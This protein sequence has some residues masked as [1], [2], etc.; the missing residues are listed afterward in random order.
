MLY[1][2]LSIKLS[3]IDHLPFP[4]IDKT[5]IGN[6]IQHHNI[7]L[8]TLCGRKMSRGSL[9]SKST[10]KVAFPPFHR[11]FPGF[12]PAMTSKRKTTKRIT[13][14]GPIYGSVPATSTGRRKQRG[15]GNLWGKAVNRDRGVV[16]QLASQEPSQTLFCFVLLHLFTKRD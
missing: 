10:R 5:C 1:C 8:P 9:V 6:F 11:P 7:Q 13:R 4:P 2:K 16:H 14:T 3:S 12:N 15:F